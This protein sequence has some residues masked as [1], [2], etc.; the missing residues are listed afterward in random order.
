MNVASLLITKLRGLRLVLAAL[1][2]AA[3]VVWFVAFGLLL[4]PASALPDAGTDTMN[5]TGEVGVLS[6]LGEETISFAGTFT[7]QRG[8]PYDD[9]GVDVVD[10]EILSLELQGDS[11]TG[12]VT[13]VN[14]NT[15]ASLGEIRS[16]QSSEMFPASSYFEIFIEASI[17]VSGSRSAPAVH[18]EETIRLVPMV[19]GQE[20]S[21]TAWPPI[22]VVYR[23]TLDPCVPLL[24]ELPAEICLTDVLIE[25]G[26]LKTPAPSATATPL[27]ATPTPTPTATLSPT[28]T[29]VPRATGDANC[30]DT[31]NA[32]D[33]AFI[34]QFVA[35]LASSLPCPDVADASGD[36]VID[37]LDAVLILQFA[38]GLIDS[39]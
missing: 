2:S 29:E 28:P 26:A 19:S 30:D 17:P 39:L 35:A 6:R 1:V 4:S 20:V 21:L 18:N 3:I 16:L 38:A 34:L 36:G 25:I 5:L 31:V 13:V 32:I 10:T 37:A 14:S 9:A 8:D 7:V 12:L 22:G 15:L 24:P 23:V 11:L 27:P 33:A